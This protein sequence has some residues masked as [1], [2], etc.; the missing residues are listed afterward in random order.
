MV[1]DGSGF[2]DEFMSDFAINDGW[3]T[4]FK[5]HNSMIRHGFL[6]IRG[7]VGA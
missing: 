3:G 4:L 7:S 6:K 1:G 5:D 2:K